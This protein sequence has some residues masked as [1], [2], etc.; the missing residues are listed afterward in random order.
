M[1][2]YLVAVDLKSGGKLLSEIKTSDLTIG[3]NAFGLNSSVLVSSDKWEQK[4]KNLL[5]RSCKWLTDDKWMI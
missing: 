2:V 1:D 4:C 5:Y 3:E